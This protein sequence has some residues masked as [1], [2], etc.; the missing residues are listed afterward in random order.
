VRDVAFY[1]LWQLVWLLL[2]F[3]K[4]K[5]SAHNLEKLEFIILTRMNLSPLIPPY[6]VQTRPLKKDATDNPM[7]ILT[8]LFVLI[9][10]LYYKHAKTQMI[11]ISI[12]KP[13]FLN[14]F[15]PNY[16]TIKALWSMFVQRHI[17]NKFWSFIESSLLRLSSISLQQSKSMFYSKVWWS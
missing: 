7:G 13:T 10:F 2:N 9:T 12:K 17:H 8:T 3:N 11:I 16:T 5:V 4:P 6:A 1:P 14:G 15:V